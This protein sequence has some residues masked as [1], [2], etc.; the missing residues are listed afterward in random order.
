M[1]GRRVDS[2]GWIQWQVAPCCW[3]VNE[4]TYSVKCGM[5][6]PKRGPISSS[7]WLWSIESVRCDQNTARVCFSVVDR[8]LTFLS[9]K[10]YK[11]IAHKRRNLDGHVT[12][13]TVRPVLIQHF[14]PTKRM[15]ATSEGNCLIFSILSPTL[16]LISKM[17][18]FDFSGWSLKCDFVKQ[19][20]SC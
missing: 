11:L 15:C 10:Q 2:W 14:V 3:H 1:I 20:E 13:S 6:F 17:T 16:S 5:F 7:K 18:T 4:E 8:T 9:R 12:R 19:L